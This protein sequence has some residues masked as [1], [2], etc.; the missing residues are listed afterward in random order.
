MSL[1]NVSSSKN[2]SESNYRETLKEIFKI[3]SFSDPANTQKAANKSEVSNLR[4]IASA[5]Y[6]VDY[7]NKNRKLL[8]TAGDYVRI[9]S[10]N[11]QRRNRFY[12]SKFDNKYYPGAGIKEIHKNPKLLNS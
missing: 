3:Y 9:V 4:D 5:R 6:Q 2:I 11:E 10:S 12:A 7:R 1:K 8:K